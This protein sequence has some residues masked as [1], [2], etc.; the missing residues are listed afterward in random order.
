MNLYL[1]DSK[2]PELSVEPSCFLIL[3]LQLPLI[4]PNSESTQH[5]HGRQNK[6]PTIAQSSDSAI[7]VFKCRG[8]GV[9][10]EET[11]EDEDVFPVNT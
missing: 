9:E 11:G 7:S 5:I 6:S 1:A 3:S 10:K 4:S 8:W 2:A